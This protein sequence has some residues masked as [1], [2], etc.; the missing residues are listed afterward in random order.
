MLKQYHKINILGIQFSQLTNQQLIKQLTLD[1]EQQQCRFIVTAN[2]EIVLYARKHF[3]YAAILKQADLITADGIGIV[4]GAKLLGQPLPE[5]VTGFDTLQQLLKVAEKKQKSVYF[6]GARATV[7]NTALKNI[8]RQY[9]K[10]IIAGYHDGYY[11]SA[12]EIGQTI[13]QLQ[14]DIVLVALGF[15]KQETFI[16]QYAAGTHAIW[17]GVGGSFDVIAGK[18]KRAPLFWQKH[19]IEWCYRLLQEP[20]RLPRMLALPK[21]LLLVLGQKFHLVH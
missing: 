20:S 17:M 5:R 10:L 21:Y 1:L 3:E 16:S 2:P 12:A 6:L 18:V 11:Q 8:Q 7:L 19:H 9:P 15:P 14:P 4:I 13:K